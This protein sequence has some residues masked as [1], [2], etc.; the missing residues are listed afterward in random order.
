MDIEQPNTVFRNL[1]ASG[2]WQA[3]TAEAGLDAAPQ[4]GI[5]VWRLEILTETG[6]WMW[7]SR[8]SAKTRRFGRIEQKAQATGW[9]LRWRA[10]RAIVTGLERW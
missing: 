2:Q 6:A 5:E 8:R 10:P 1:G 4:P 9:M 7:S 3:L